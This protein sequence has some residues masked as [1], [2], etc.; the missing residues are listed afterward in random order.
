LVKRGERILSG[1]EELLMRR[2]IGVVIDERESADAAEYGR[3]NWGIWRL[4]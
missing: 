1:I 2:W 3:E 4:G